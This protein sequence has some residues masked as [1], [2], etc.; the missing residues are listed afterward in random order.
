MATITSAIVSNVNMTSIRKRLGVSSPMHSKGMAG[1]LFWVRVLG[2]SKTFN[3]WNANTL[4]VMTITVLYI[5]CRKN[6]NSVSIS[7][8]LHGIE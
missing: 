8:Q 2:G 3:N 5:P 4:T 1:T 6:E 7:K